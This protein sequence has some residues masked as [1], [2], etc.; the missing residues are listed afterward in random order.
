[1]G[2]IFSLRPI[3]MPFEVTIQALRQQ[4]GAALWARHFDPETMLEAGS[5]SVRRGSPNVAGLSRRNPAGKGG[6]I[7]GRPGAKR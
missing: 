6:R 2:A 1:M 3:G 7:V 5:G 4:H